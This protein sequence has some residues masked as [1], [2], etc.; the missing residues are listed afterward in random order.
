M[1][2]KEDLFNENQVGYPEDKMSMEEAER[3]WIFRSNETLIE[4]Y[5]D[6]G[7]DLNDAVFNFFT[8][9]AL[10]KGF[11]IYYWFTMC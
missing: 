6:L 11:A 10:F 3:I 7:G 8:I 4:E 1:L 9:L 5:L 2:I